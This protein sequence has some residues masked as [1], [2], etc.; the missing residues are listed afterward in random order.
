MDRKAVAN[1]HLETERVKRA[2]S[3]AHQER[4]EIESFYDG[5]D[6]TEPLTRATFEE[7]N[8]DLVQEVHPT[9]AES[10]GQLWS[11][12]DP[13]RRNCVGWWTHAH[14]QGAAAFQGLLRR[15]V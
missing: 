15:Q 12:E 2:L 5:T 8:I 10:H 11:E 3:S 4:I 13:D 9:R 6:R 1:L 14:S 7:L